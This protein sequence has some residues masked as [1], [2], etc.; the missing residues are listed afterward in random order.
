MS[1]VSIKVPEPCNAED[2]W[3]QAP[4]SSPAAHSALSQR[5]LADG[6]E[7]NHLQVVGIRRAQLVHHPPGAHEGPLVLC[8]DAFVWL[9]TDLMGSADA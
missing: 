7:A 6:V 9:S 1:S 5:A 8:N 4:V 3:E 2:S